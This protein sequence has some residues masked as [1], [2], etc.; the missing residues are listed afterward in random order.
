MRLVSGA[1][2]KGPIRGANVAFYALDGFGFASGAAVASTTTDS[3][4]NFSI[5]LPA[6]V[7]AVL[8]ETRGGSFID[9]SDQ[10]TDPARKR[11]I[12]LAATEGFVSILATGASTVAVTPFTEALVTRARSEAQA[13]GGFLTRLDTAVSDFSAVTGFNVL[14]TVPADP[15]APASTATAEA[16]QYALMLGGIAN[17]T[18]NMAIQLGSATPTYDIIKAV[19]D[20]LVDGT[21]NGKRYSNAVTVTVAGTRQ[22]LPTD[23]SL[24][25]EMSRFASNNFSTYSAVPVPVVSVGVVAN[26]APQA[27]AGAD[28]DIPQATVGSLNGSASFDPDQTALTYAWTQVSGTPVTLSSTTVASPTFTAPTTLLAPVSL[29][30]Q[31]TVTDAGGLSATDSVIVNVTPAINNSSAYVLQTFARPY[32]FGRDIAG[33]GKLIFNAEGAGVLTDENTTANFSYSVSGAVLT[34]DFTAMGGLTRDQFTTF[35][36]LNAAGLQDMLQVTEKIDRYVLTLVQDGVGEDLFSLQSVGNRTTFN[37]SLNLAVSSEVINTTEAVSVFDFKGQSTFTIS[38]GQKRSLLTNVS[39]SVPTLVDAPALRLDGLTFQTDGSGFAAEKNLAFTWRIEADGH[40]QVTF[41]DGDTARYYQL[42]T[43]PSGNVVVADYTYANA[44]VRAAAELSFV[45]DPARNWNA[46]TLSGIYVARGSFTLNN[47]S[48]VADDVS[49]RLSPDGTGL[50]EFQLYDAISGAATPGSSALGI[51]W[52]VNTAG[53]LV[54]DHISSVG[55]RFPDSRQP[56]TSACASLTDDLVGFRRVQSLYDQNGVQLRTVIKESKNACG[57][58]PTAGCALPVTDYIPRILERTATFNGNPPLATNATI[59]VV[60]SAAVSF[61]GA[62][63]AV[64]DDSSLD[65]ASVVIVKQPL[66]GAVA[67]NNTTGVITYTPVGNAGKDEF[68][69]TVKDVQGNLS[70][71]GRISVVINPPVAVATASNLAPLQAET[72][73]LNGSASTDNLGVVSYAWTQTSGT[74]VTLSDATLASPTFIAP[75]TVETLT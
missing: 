7:G 64:D 70:N 43:R 1:A 60:N 24:E 66:T 58:A 62:A 13:T 21:V 42:A 75:N 28:F 20:D 47:G 27:V 10:E 35:S 69:F 12:V 71:V 31:L 39:S 74:V 51:C 54:F 15:L 34:L 67:V 3:S 57:F 32:Q 25:Q 41:A 33:G 19:I 29:L 50:V 40:L 14:T 46:A 55:Q 68:Y 17:V 11:Q 30:F 45:N 59:T 4:G 72:V 37:A 38:A 2:T 8:V 65:L 73:T 52:S 26:P 23:V 49:Y 6:S 44:S 61:A 5:S 56:S 9:E 22:A 48:I 63:V 16:S 18:N 36:P 53:D